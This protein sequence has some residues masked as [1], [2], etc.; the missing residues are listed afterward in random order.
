M[1]AK[2]LA[3]QVTIEGLAQVA[4]AQGMEHASYVLNAL[5]GSIGCEDEKQLRFAVQRFVAR[6]IEA[7]M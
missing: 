7:E 3:M 4:A 5:A 6:Q 2:S 1:D